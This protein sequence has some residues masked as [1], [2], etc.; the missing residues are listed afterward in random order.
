MKNH[1][2][3]AV[4]SDTL[5]VIYDYFQKIPQMWYA[6]ENYCVVNTHKHI[7]NDKS[8]V[9]SDAATGLLS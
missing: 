3:D 4:N 9:A 7:K 6:Y 1:Y 5:H 8:P 2:K